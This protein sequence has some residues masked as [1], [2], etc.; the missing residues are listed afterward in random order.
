MSTKKCHY[1]GCILHISL[2]DLG[3]MPLANSLV[4]PARNNPDN[5]WPLHAMA[6]LECG[7]V[8]LTTTV[9]ADAIF[10]HDY[11]Y[12]SSFST[13]WVTQ[14][15]HYVLNMIDRF[16]LTED[17]LVVEV[18]SNDG[19]LLR[20]FVASRI[21]A[22]G[23][24]PSGEVAQISQKYGIETR[25]MFF[26]EESAKELS[27]KGYSADLMVANNVL[28][29]VPDLHDFVAGF[30]LILKQ[31]GVLTIEV[32]HLLN[33]IEQVQFDTIYHE[34]YSYFSL[35]TVMRVLSGVGLRVF[36]VERLCSHG[37]SLRIFVCHDGATYKNKAVV[38]DILKQES[39]SG[40]AAEHPYIIFRDKTQEIINTF[41]EFVRDAEDREKSIFGYG[42]AAKGITFINACGLDASSIPLCADAN[43][44]KQGKLM[45]GSHIPIVSP[46][47]MLEHKPDYVVIFPWNIAE[48]VCTQLAPIRNWGGR[49][50]TASGSVKVF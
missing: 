8:Q 50:V 36:D 4:H 32:P 24:E 39:V 38:Q 46:Q 43:P 29:H 45:P 22:L 31:E 6:C 48:E 34:H 41:I 12:H 21:P 30:P 13:S 3:E 25:V 20:H 35:A 42:A 10:T 37:G 47:E 49:F 15:E 17:S 28:A 27:S 2:I 40:L 26:N 1:C 23:I 33:L 14:C 18:A 9:P 19:Y 44:Y 5:K 16:G 7:L 11:A